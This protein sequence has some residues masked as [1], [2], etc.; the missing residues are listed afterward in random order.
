M[1]KKN[2]TIQSKDSANPIAIEDL[3]A[4]MIELSETEL[5][6]IMGGWISDTIVIVGRTQFRLWQLTGDLAQKVRQILY[7]PMYLP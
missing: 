3:P 7:D 6:Q 2:L 4:E 1:Y 5:E